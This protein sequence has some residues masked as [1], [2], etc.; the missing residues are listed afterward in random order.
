M[1]AEA[2]QWR[3]APNTCTRVACLVSALA[4]AMLL[5]HDARARNALSEPPPAHPRDQ[6]RE[7]QMKIKPS[8]TLVAVGDKFVDLAAARSGLRAAIL[9]GE[10]YPEKG[11]RF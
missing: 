5:P 1:Y 6:S 10:L 9:T 2:G 7:L 3:V 11:L 8:F 4:A